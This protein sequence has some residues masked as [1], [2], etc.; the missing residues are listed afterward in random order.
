MA[1]TIGPEGN[2]LDPRPESCR[3]IKITYPVIDNDQLA[4]LRYVYEP[5]FRSIT[6]PMH[7]DPGTDHAK[8]TKGT[9]DAT[10]TKDTRVTGKGLEQALDDLMRRPSHAVDAG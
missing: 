4:K 3:Q 1:S 9:K 8:D 10:G 5:G 6:L 2:L 7:F